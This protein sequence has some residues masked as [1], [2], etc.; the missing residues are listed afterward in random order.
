M[1]KLKTKKSKT[2]VILTIILMFVI[3]CFV[4]MENFIYCVNQIDNDLQITVNSE[5]KRSDDEDEVLDIYDKL[6]QFSGSYLLDFSSYYLMKYGSRIDNIN[7]LGGKLP[8]NLYFSYEDS[9]GNIIRTYA[10]PD[11]RALNLNDEEVKNL[12]DKGYLEKEFSDG[13]K[14]FYR[15][16]RVGKGHAIVSY[17]AVDYESMGLEY[18]KPHSSRKDEVIIWLDSENTIVASNIDKYLDKKLDQVAEGDINA[19]IGVAKFEDYG[20]GLCESVFDD[21]YTLSVFLPLSTI[22][23]EVFRNS[24]VPVV[25]FWIVVITILNY[26]L[27]I[28]REIDADSKKSSRNIKKLGKIAFDKEI[29]LHVVSLALFGVILIGLTI[30]YVGSLVS[31][32]D[33]NQIASENLKGL[34]E[35]YNTNQLNKEVAL[36]NLE[37]EFVEYADYVSWMYMHN[38][39]DLSSDSLNSLIDSV[40]MFNEIMVTDGNGTIVASTSND[41]G[42][43]LGRND[44]QINTLC[45]Q[46][47]DGEM[48][49]AMYNRGTSN[50][51]FDFSILVRRQDA[52]GVIIIDMSIN[53]ASD[54]ME[55]WS[56]EETMLTT[57]MGDASSI[58]FFRD[59]PDV[60]YMALPDADKI[61]YLDATL[62]EKM[63]TNGFAGMQRIKGVKYYVNTLLNTDYD[64]V[65]IS[66]L[67]IKDIPYLVAR[68]SL[69][70]IILGVAIFVIILI[71][72]LAIVK[73]S[74]DVIKEDNEASNN[75]FSAGNHLKLHFESDEFISEGFKKVIINMIITNGILLVLLLGFDYMIK[76]EPLLEYLLGSEWSKGVNLFSVTMILIILVGS[77]LVSFVWNKL[78]QMI[79]NNMGPRGMTVGH[80]IS[81]LSKFIILVVAVIWSLKEL[82]FNLSALLTGAGIAGAAI[83]LCANSTVND[84]LSGFFIVFEGAYKIGDWVKVSDWRGQVLGIGM[85]T[86]K[87]AHGG[88][89]MV[90]NNSSMTN[91]TVMDP[92]NSGAL[93]AIDIAYKEDVER[94]IKLIDDNK[95]RYQKEIKEI[96]DGPFVKGVVELGTNGVTI[97]IYAFTDQVYAAK[98]ERDIRLLTK[99]LFNEND[100]EIPFAQLTIHQAKE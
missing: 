76:E 24:I 19:Q 34:S 25:L 15:T 3:S 98:V 46:I 73:P 87:I 95:D 11:S 63:T 52:K 75:K 10:S 68:N 69:G 89:I 99:R 93:V 83:S 56:L 86:T 94:V 2:I 85:R 49:S 80:L 82:G 16:K 41:E 55:N 44:N 43:T 72:S 57:D 20:Y 78:I 12:F 100:I 22:F 53:H 70:I 58:A 14:Y 9:N 40:S 6:V 13:T 38:P 96:D 4:F 36:N 54:F 23:S 71:F 18:G 42:Y 65:F 91:V 45:W 74:E 21:G 50:G 29:I 90:L 26:V 17:Q 60:I 47:M 59:N 30:F 31:Y 1:K 81:S 61:D 39:D 48:D 79:F 84:L 77:L 97:E 8:V 35:A 7:L 51:G 92:S 32:S 28:K 33:Q 5:L 66:A 67:P 27:K 62:N 88:N 37:A 64:L